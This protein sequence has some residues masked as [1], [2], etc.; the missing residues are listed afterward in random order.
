MFDRKS[1]KETLRLYVEGLCSWAPV[2]M[3]C[4]LMLR[5]PDPEPFM[6]IPLA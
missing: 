4:R 5:R 2:A 1:F 3:D 6:P